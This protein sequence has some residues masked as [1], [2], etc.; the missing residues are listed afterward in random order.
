MT[1]D[2]ALFDFACH[3]ADQ[4]GRVIAPY[5][6]NLETVERK[7]GK[8]RFDPVTIAD[9]TAEQVIREQIEK[10]YPE[11]GILGE[12]TGTTNPDAEFCWSIDPIDGTRAFIGGLLSWGTLIALKK[13]RAPIIGIMDQPFTRERYMA[14]PGAALYRNPAG[15]AR[16]LKTRTGIPLDNAVI[17]T[18]SPRAFANTQDLVAFQSLEEATKFSL[19]GGNCVAYCLLAAGQIDVV[20]ET[21]LNPYDID[22]LVPIITEAGGLVCNWT[23]GDDL[24]AGQAVACGDPILLDQVL[25]YLSPAAAT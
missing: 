18:T 3:L 1:D 23:G 13:N 11:H 6:R 19:Y 21:A 7:P 22:A 10:T 16:A 2:Q 25:H 5:F 17:A 24:S 15:Q 14:Q 8:G 4:S 9:R 20:A 12:E